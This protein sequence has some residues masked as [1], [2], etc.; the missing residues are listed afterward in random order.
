MDSTSVANC[1][2][3]LGRYAPPVALMGLIFFL[4]NQPHLTSG[5][6]VWDLIGRKLIHAT[7]YGLLFALWWR[8]LGWRRWP[9]AAAIGTGFAMTDEFHQTYIAG[10]HGTPVD[11]L[12]DSSG[13]AIAAGLI[14]LRRNR[15]RRGARRQASA[16]ST[17]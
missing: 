3:A 6:G 8:A 10:R 14:L 2:S 13:V 16:A 4:S 17:A 12:I 5:L 11:V 9:L 15:L 1:M 7:E